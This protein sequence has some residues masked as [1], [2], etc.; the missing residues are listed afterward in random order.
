MTH[1][2]HAGRRRRAFARARWRCR[3]RASGPWRAIGAALVLAGALSG[4][5][6]DGTIAVDTSNPGGDTT[7]VVRGTVYAP[8]GE[9]AAAERVPNWFRLPALLGT[10]YAASNPNVRPVGGGA[11]VSLL[12]VSEID[13]AD[14]KVESAV[15]LGQALSNLDGAYKITGSD[16]GRVGQCGVMTAAGGGELLMRSF[17]LTNVTDIDVCTETTVRVV[18]RRL[19]EAPPAQLC[20]FDAREI[21][22]LQTIVCDATFTAAADNVSEL[23]YA[24]FQLADDDPCVVD[25]VQKATGTDTDGTPETCL[26]YYVS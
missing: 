22:T 10:A 13:A 20:D 21:R 12:R 6:S 4:C 16:A 7:A 26:H 23:N 8:N 1:A 5:G 3:A 15:L 11:I 14:G 25:A 9:I 17:A 24:A 19:T 2:I 18:L